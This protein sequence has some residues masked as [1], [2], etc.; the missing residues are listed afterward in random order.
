[1]STKYEIP[2][3]LR[4]WCEATAP[5]LMLHDWELCRALVESDSDG[6]L[7]DGPDAVVTPEQARALLAYADECTRCA[8]CGAPSTC[9]GSY[10]DHEP[11]EGACD[12]CCGHGCEDGWCKQHDEWDYGRY[13]AGRAAE[14]RG[15]S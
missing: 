8:H 2:A 15:D 6:V 3:N 11:V 4:P 1:M 9:V 10:E 5:T 13:I 14:L 7:L 12:T